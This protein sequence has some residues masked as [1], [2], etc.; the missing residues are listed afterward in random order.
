MTTLQKNVVEKLCESLNKNFIK[1]IIL[2]IEINGEKRKGQP[3]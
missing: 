1:N 3:R 2:S